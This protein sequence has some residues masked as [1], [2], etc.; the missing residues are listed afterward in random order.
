M[1]FLDDFQ[2]ILGITVWDILGL[3]WHYAH[4]PPKDMTLEEQIEYLMES[5]E[6]FARFLMEIQPDLNLRPSTVNVTF[7]EEMPEQVIRC[8]FSASIRCPIPA[9]KKS[10]ESN[11]RTLQLA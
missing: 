5:L 11:M 7:S 4:R 8:M 3:L 9:N 2:P 10:A 1:I 6:Q